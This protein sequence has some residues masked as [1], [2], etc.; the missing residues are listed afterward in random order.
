MS[1][2]INKRVYEEIKEIRNSGETN[3]FAYDKVMNIAN[4]R[5]MYSLVSWMN[6]NKHKYF[7]G[8]IEG[9]EVKGD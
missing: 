4:N 2:K 5:D 9:F 8:I 3:M 1:I 6:Q 7:D